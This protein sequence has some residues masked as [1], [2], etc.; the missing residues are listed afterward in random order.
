MVPG[1][2]GLD[3][4]TPLMRRTPAVE[5]DVD[6]GLRKL[7]PVE[8]GILPPHAKLMRIDGSVSDSNE[9]DT[10]YLLPPVG[11][12]NTDSAAVPGG[13]SQPSEETGT[14]RLSAPMLDDIQDTAN[15]TTDTQ[16]RRLPSV[17]QDAEAGT[18]EGTPPEA[19][20]LPEPKP[21][22]ES[23]SELDLESESEP[24]PAPEPEPGGQLDGQLDDVRSL[25]P[26]ESALNTAPP[27]EPPS[28][29]S[30]T[31]PPDP[32]ADDALLLEPDRSDDGPWVAVNPPPS[33]DDF[34]PSPRPL[35]ESRHLA[36]GAVPQRL[37]AIEPMVPSEYS[38]R[39]DVIQDHATL[40]ALDD[41][42]GAAARR[43]ADLAVR[44]A[45]F[46]A[47][48]ELLKALRAITQTL[49]ARAGTREHSDALARAVR[50]FQ[51]ACDFTPRGSRL[52]ADLD[53][54]LIVS[55]H[56]TP[57]LKSEH[58][59]LL[60]PVTAQ[61][62]YLHYARA[63]FVMACGS[64]PAASQAL[65]ALARVYTLMDQ[66][67]VETQT[68]GV[69]QA[70]ALHQAALVVDP[71]NSRAANELGVLLAN[72][73]RL[74]EARQALLHSVSVRP[75]AAAWH[76]LSVV[77]QRLGQTE[78]ARRASE[79]AIAFAG[80][81]GAPASDAPVRSVHW[82]DPQAFSTA[83]ALRDPRAD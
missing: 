3:T 44:G 62:R 11:E 18:A 5:Y 76:N 48:A 81:D 31:V 56:R 41:Q 33:I 73:G 47:R 12:E 74:E 22:S 79:Q 69:P 55:G 38:T 49:D 46:A 43:A 83:P 17:E 70:I 68:L 29:S 65:Y 13:T 23:E 64:L 6:D 61:Q 52:E 15:P 51:E 82:V 27:T 35:G 66:A 67:H 19:L 45:Y 26:L 2:D 9:E 16:L 71:R 50:A 54:A 80:E 57:V 78:L 30:E 53:L 7:P 59:D 34:A 75:E 14:R 40:S 37:P 58:L 21:E 36:H 20:A 24:A 25:P 63:Q 60:T 42:V 77:H 4:D 39:I 1:I 32:L 10:L 72:G 28:I 8:P